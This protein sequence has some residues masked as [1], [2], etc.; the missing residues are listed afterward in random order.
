[1]YF[2]SDQQNVLIEHL[3]LIAKHSKRRE[4]VR[5]VSHINP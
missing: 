1:M 5:V 2:I 3:A 4:S